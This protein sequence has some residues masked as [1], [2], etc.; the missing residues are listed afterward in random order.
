MGTHTNAY[1]RRKYNLFLPHLNFEP[2]FDFPVSRRK[3]KKISIFERCKNGFTLSRIRIATYH[4]ST[5]ILFR[6]KPYEMFNNVWYF[7]P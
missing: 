3:K 4:F 5:N 7:S 6:L 1:H 2:F